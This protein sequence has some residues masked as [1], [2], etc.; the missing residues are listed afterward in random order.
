MPSKLACWVAGVSVNQ[1][2]PKD[3]HKLLRHG[4]LID[5]LV[6]F[7]PV[8]EYPTPF[9]IVFLWKIKSWI[10]KTFVGKFV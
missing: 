2:V 10:L 5:I 3:G 4:Q 8:G 6:T 9:P 7:V 1:N